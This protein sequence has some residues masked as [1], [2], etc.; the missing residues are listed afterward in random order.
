MVLD[1]PDLLFSYLADDM[2]LGKTF[3]II[4]FL[5]GLMRRDEIKRVLI[6]SPVSVITEILEH[7]APHVKVLSETRVTHAI[8]IHD[9]YLN[10]QYHILT[11]IFP[12]SSELLLIWF[13]RM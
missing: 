11:R 9:K 13:V 6:I 5:T 7:I 2:G 12:Y 1:C 3:Q 10:S 8:C 4:A